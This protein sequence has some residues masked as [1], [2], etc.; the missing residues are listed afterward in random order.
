MR[1]AAAGST[2]CN[3]LVHQPV[4]CNFHSVGIK[5]DLA[6]SCILQ[7]YLV[8]VQQLV[9]HTYMYTVSRRSKVYLNERNDVD[10]SCAL[11]CLIIHIQQ[12]EAALSKLHSE[13]NFH[14]S[15]AQI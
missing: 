8:S 10:T 9:C 13:G 6:S 15:Q 3:T 5:G 1:R 7:L 12:Y 11:S 14:K 4:Q 2:M